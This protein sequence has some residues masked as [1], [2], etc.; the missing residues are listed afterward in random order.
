MK[1]QGLVLLIAITVIVGIFSGC[2]EKVSLQGSSPD[3][4]GEQ[5]T[6]REQVEELRGIAGR[7]EVPVTKITTGTISSILSVTGELVPRKSVIV[8]PMM[9][10][11]IT[12]LKPIKVGDIV[13]EGDLIAKIDDRDIE[14]E[15]TRQIREIEITKE[16][17]KLDES[18]FAQ[19][20]KDLEF[21]RQLFKEGYLNEAEIRK[22]E[23]NLKRAE[24]ALRQSRL[25]LEQEEDKL[26]QALRKREKV[27]I[28]AP[29]SGMVV[30]ASHL[31]GQ[32]GGSDLLSEEIMSLEDTLVGTGSQLFGIVSQD[33]FLAQC[34]VNSKDKAKIE[35]GQKALVTVISHKAVEAPGEVIKIDQLQD[36]KTRAYKVWIK[37][38]ETDKSFASGLFVRANIE[39]DRSEN[40]M[41]IPREF[42]K[43]REDK[44]F[45]QIIKQNT[46]LDIFVPVGIRQGKLI[47][48][49]SLDVMPG[50]LLV[51]TEKVIAVNQQ[52]TPKIMEKEKEEKEEQN[53]IVAPMMGPLP[54]R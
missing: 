52:V 29:I 36:V 43:E 15:I 26:K 33:D 20:Q 30:L 5:K 42:L 19:N 37:I 45:V 9:D 18:E 51:A 1:K 40:T 38:N 16:K 17:I 10:G 28:K 25:S 4:K 34:L 49:T 11:R 2:G 35:L 54:A 47:E 39:L 6:L 50:D 32:G 22:T 13:S 12:F 21:D 14:D 23:M 24:I 7:I 53:K 8:K 48:I 44:Y 3:K 27:P 46:V 41:V 31:T